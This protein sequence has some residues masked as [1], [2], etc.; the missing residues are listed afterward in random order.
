[1]SPAI[2]RKRSGNKIALQFYATRLRRS[3]EYTANKT[4]IMNWGSKAEVLEPESLRDEIRIE[5]EVMLGKYTK[6]IEKEGKPLR[7]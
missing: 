4:G 1:M 3:L 2:S 6:G 5:A 7:A